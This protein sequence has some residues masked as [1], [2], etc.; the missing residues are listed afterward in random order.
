MQI[1]IIRFLVVVMMCGL[2][3][4]VMALGQN[5]DAARDVVLNAVQD[6]IALDGYHLMLRSTYLNNITP[7]DGTVTR[8]YTLQTLEGDVAS[9]G[10]RQF[11]REIYTGYTLA[12]AAQSD[13]FVVEQVVSDGVTYVNFVVAGTIHEGMLDIQPGWWEYNQLIESVD[14][15]ITSDA[16]QPYGQTDTPLDVVFRPETVLSAEEL[17]PQVVD[18]MGLR[19]FEV[20][21]DAVQLLLEQAPGAEAEKQDFLTPSEDLLAASEITASYRLWIGAD[22]GLVYRGLGEQISNIPYAAAG[23]NSDPDFDVAGGGNVEFTIS[24]HGEAVDI[25]PPDADSLN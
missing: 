17:E 3:L 13:A 5:D 25:T 1:R 10:D 9:N 21:L 22:D 19:V 23:S 2:V 7:R 8:T 20:E 15:T 12:R 16:L 6:T 4:P 18:G 24:Q 14:S 11:I